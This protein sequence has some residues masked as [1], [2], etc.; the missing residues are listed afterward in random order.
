LLRIPL[1]LIHCFLRHKYLEGSQSL[2]VYF[3]TEQNRKGG[4]VIML[5]LDVE[6]IR[7]IK[8]AL[9]SIGVGDRNIVFGS[10]H[11]TVH[12]LGSNY[13]QISMSGNRFPV[14]GFESKPFIVRWLNLMSTASADNI[15]EINQNKF[16]YLVK[17]KPSC[18]DLTVSSDRTEFALSVPNNMI[19][20]PDFFKAYRNCAKFLDRRIVHIYSNSLFI[21]GNALFAAYGA[22]SIIY[23]DAVPPKIVAILSEDKRGTSYTERRAEPKD[24][25]ETH[26]LS[27]SLH[28]LLKNRKCYL[29][30]V[31]DFLAIVTRSF[32]TYGFLTPY[33][34]STHYVNRHKSGKRIFDTHIDKALADTIIKKIELLCLAYLPTGETRTTIIKL[35]TID[36]WVYAINTI[37]TEE[38]VR[39]YRI[40]LFQE[41]KVLTQPVYVNALDLKKAL[42]YG[43][44]DFTVRRSYTYS[45]GYADVPLG[46]VLLVFSNK[47]KKRHITICSV[48]TVRDN[49]TG[50]IYDIDDIDDNGNIS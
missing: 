17:G 44:A 18:T 40:K 22:L 27:H 29:G 3:Y 35:K 28:F 5:R 4:S 15:V 37:K 42:R 49:N 31:N 10:K 1:S 16:N 24:L 47:T 7:L 12:L 32:V 46:C 30:V 45:E 36:G 38:Q 21:Y 23:E 13:L 14:T 11:I 6:Q 34:L 50:C 19:E 26:A 39:S 25:R 41:T 20:A 2:C 43:E 33:K 9:D 48:D 8:E